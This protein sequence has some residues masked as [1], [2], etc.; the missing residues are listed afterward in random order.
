MDC[1]VPIKAMNMSKHSLAV[2]KQAN[3]ASCLWYYRIMGLSHFRNVNYAEARSLVRLVLSSVRD[4][5]SAHIAST[6][7]A[8]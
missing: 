8:I 6:C 2:G 1:V 3:K 4:A 5:F 7:E